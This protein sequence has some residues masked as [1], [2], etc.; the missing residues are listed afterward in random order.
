MV[1]IGVMLTVRRF[2]V[3]LGADEALVVN[4]TQGT[5][6]TFGG[7]PGGM[8]VTFDVSYIQPLGQLEGWDYIT[9]GLFKVAYH[10]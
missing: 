9:I 1:Q 8:S 5:R 3:S 10:F 7:A 6:V 4:M 2:Y